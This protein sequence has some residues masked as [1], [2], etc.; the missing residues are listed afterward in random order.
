MSRVEVAIRK[1]GLCRAQH[2]L[3]FLMAVSTMIN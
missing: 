1:R 3:R 2:N